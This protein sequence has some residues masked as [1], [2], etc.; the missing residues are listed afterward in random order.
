MRKIL[1]LFCLLI[2][3]LPNVNYVSAENKKEWICIANYCYIYSEP[4]FAS[5][6]VVGEDNEP[7][8]V[9]HKDVLILEEGENR[10]NTYLDSEG[11][12]FYAVLSM[13]GVE[14]NGYIFSD[15]VTEDISKI[16]TYPTFNATLK[17]DTYLFEVNGE[18][19]SE[20]ETLLES[21]TRVYLYEGFDNDVNGYNAVAV[22][23]G[24]TLQYGY[25]LK[26]D[27]SPDGINPAIIY[28]ITI[29]LAC[30]GIIM[31]FLFM[32]NKKNKKKMSH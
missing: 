2:F 8:I 29:A 21:G 22:K 1:L 24:N 20:T 32:K 16:E 30:I 3:C 5:A 23:V 31:A 11:Q 4:S 6:K 27:V 13:E 26:S 25:V 15:F 7:I 18:E 9:K 12:I 10:L 17:S 19:F 28:A 14:I